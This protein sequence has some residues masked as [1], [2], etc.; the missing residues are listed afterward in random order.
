MEDELMKRG[1]DIFRKAYKSSEVEDLY[2]KELKG[3]T[4]TLD[5]LTMLALMSRMSA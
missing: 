3:N 2:K 1:I 5:R 4:L